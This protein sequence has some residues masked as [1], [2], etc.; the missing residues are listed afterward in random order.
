MRVP[1][2]MQGPSET[3]G[4]RPSQGPLRGAVEEGLT[5]LD[6]VLATGRAELT[7]REV[8][9]VVS[10]GQGVARLRGLP[11]VQAGSW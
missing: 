4:P 5:V 10:V 11:S 7:A 3:S 8:G 1:R 6:E 9:R 2:S